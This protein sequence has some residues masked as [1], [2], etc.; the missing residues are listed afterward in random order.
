M[1]NFLK[2]RGVLHVTLALLAS[3]VI[4]LLSGLIA[5]AESRDGQKL[6]TESVRSTAH[7]LSHQIESS[8][9]ELDTLLKIVTQ[10]YQDR[11][12]KSDQEL[13]RLDELMRQDL[14]QYKIALRVAVTDAAGNQLFNSARPKGSKREFPNIADRSYFQRARDGEAGL[15]F[16]G[17]LE[18]KLDKT[19]SIFMARRISGANGDFQG[20]VLVAV[21]IR[22]LNIGF[23]HV[24]LGSKGIINLRTS[25]MRQVVRYPDLQG[26]DKGVGNRN[27]SNVIQDIMRD[28][29]DQSEHVYRAI[30]PMDGIDRIYIYKKFDPSPFWM[31]VGRSVDDF[32]TGRKNWILFLAATSSMIIGFLVWGAKRLDHQYAFLNE[33]VSQRTRALT[34]SE[35]RY[36]ELSNA[37]EIIIQSIPDGLIVTDLEGRIIRCNRGLLDMFGYAENELLGQNVDMLLP[38]QLQGLHAEHRPNFTARVISNNSKSQRSFAA[39]HR[40]GTEF[41]VCL[42]LSMFE[43]GESQ[44]IICTVHDV[45]LMNKALTDAQEARKLA[46]RFENLV[47]SSKDA[48]ITK[49][50]DGTVTSWNPAAEAIFGYSQA[51]MLGQSLIRLFPPGLEAE[52]DEVLAKVTA[53]RSIPTFESRRLCKDGHTV[54][55]LISVSPLFDEAG[56][57]V[58]ASKIARDITE[59][60]RDKNELLLRLEKLVQNIPGMVFQYQRWPD[61]RSAFPYASVGIRHIYGVEP[62]QVR[63]DASPVYAV[64][65]P[66]DLERVVQGI[67]E[68]AVNLTQWYDVYRVVLPAG[69]ALWVEGIATPEKMPDGSVLWSGYIRDITDRKIVEKELMQA[70]QAAEEA[71]QAKSRFLAT[72]SHEIRTPIN[73]VMGYLQLMSREPINDKM[74]GYVNESLNATRLLLRVLNDVLDFSKIEA[75][76]LDLQ[77]APFDLRAMLGEV[78]GLM[79]AQ[80]DG[81]RLALRLDIDPELPRFALADDMRLRQVLLN[82][83]SNAI[84]F[85]E[86]G[87]VTLSVR[88]EALSDGRFRLRLKITDTGIGIG[89]RQLQGLFQAFGQADG[90]ITRRFGGSGLGL[91][92]SQRLLKLMGSEGLQVQSVEG[93]GS[94]FSFELVLG[95]P[96]AAQQQML[97]EEVKPGG[98][99]QIDPAQA[100]SGEQ[101]LQGRCILLVED[102]PTNID[103]AVNMLES[104]GAEVSIAIN[105]RDALDVLQ[106]QGAHFD[107]VLMDMQMPEMDGLE[108]TRRIKAHPDWARL[109]VVAM[110]ANA[111]EQD[112]QAC[113]EAGMI[114]YLSKPYELDQLLRVVRQHACLAP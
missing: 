15:I 30:A 6:A 42:G 47:A 22:L 96:S 38:K 1:V 39:C 111:M 78:H 21:P 41:L 85:T 71:N 40:D 106:E 48:I 88:S 12:H 104:L 77:V 100:P 8:L 29:P 27:V 23:E 11:Q 44:Q 107:L 101:P 69:K 5:W 105:G 76:K 113:L 84:K 18:A 59:I 7:V 60:K 61:D 53:G 13:D 109:P 66:E 95:M 103:V 37:N 112:R 89:E 51:E 50:L 64:L 43:V 55:V 56:A 19:W 72:M 73:G 28:Y 98:A 80:L 2:N 110:T 33:L 4:A 36:R 24:D 34:G 20:V 108:A 81:R 92:I 65:H 3:F 83:T 45:S 63:E 10:R 16:E 70:K 82:L 25:D 58:G 87:T 93:K 35:K 17:P 102:N 31:V 74:H 57:I 94:S 75:G 9:D 114:D 86:R 46:S 14:P 49:T 32:D 52:E 54:D 67:E 91:V 68:S 79:Q 26:V 62:E 90:S 97:L 99:G